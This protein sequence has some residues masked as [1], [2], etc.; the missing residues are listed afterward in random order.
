MGDDV[1]SPA[2]KTLLINSVIAGT[3]NTAG[4]DFSITGSKGTG[5]GTG[6]AIVLRTAPAGGS[7]TSQ[8]AAV[9]RMRIDGAGLITAG[10][11]AADGEGLNFLFRSLTANAGYTNNNSVQPW[12]PTAGAVAVEASTSYEFEGQL[13]QTNG[14][15]SH[16]VGIS[17][18]GTATLTSI[19]YVSW[20]APSSV[21]ATITTGNT[22]QVN[23]GTAPVV[24]PA[25]TTAGTV[26]Q[27]RGI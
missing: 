10:A 19:E 3:S 22:T 26:I 11:T 14:A 25:I 15:T 6:G 17:F 18:G 9:D 16:T 4:A 20:F 27:I 8:N 24:T 21:S 2:A 13:L 1:A 7:G 23:Q 12:F 5:T